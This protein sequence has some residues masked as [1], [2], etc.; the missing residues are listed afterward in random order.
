MAGELLAHV[1]GAADDFTT[2]HR[3]AS[4]DLEYLIDQPV[5]AIRAYLSDRPAD[6][7]YL[8]SF[9]DRLRTRLANASG[10]LEWGACHG[11]F[12]STGNFR[13]RADGSIS[14]F[15]FDL[16][17]PGWRISD[18]APMQRAAVGH[19]DPRIWQSFLDG[20]TAV[21]RLAAVDL[22]AVPLFYAA[23]RLWSVGMRARHVAR[24]GTLHMGQWY[25]DWQLRVFRQWEASHGTH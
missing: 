7:G 6:W 4:M 8:S 10:E 20:Y 16:C 24:W 22:E 3:R 13:V 2:P 9:A 17:G 21:R 11:D 15:D 1:H 18:L 19:K 5:H 23:C 12:S 14:V 25:L